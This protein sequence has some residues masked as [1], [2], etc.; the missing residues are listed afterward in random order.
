MLQFWDMPAFMVNEAQLS[1][2]MFNQA[3][4]AGGS[5]CDHAQ[6][7]M[8]EWDHFIMSEWDPAIWVVPSSLFYPMSSKIY[9]AI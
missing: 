8:S 6:F 9:M 2:K 3:P 5:T 7:I 4:H 1:W